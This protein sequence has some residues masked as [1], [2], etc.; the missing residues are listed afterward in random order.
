M[1]VPPVQ[2]FDSCHVLGVINASLGFAAKHHGHGF[3]PQS[4]TQPVL[5]SLQERNLA[6]RVR[7]DQRS[8]L[9]GERQRVFDDDPAAPGLSQCVHWP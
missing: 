6:G 1:H 9:I 5:F 2:D 7:K 4:G 3:W 8:N